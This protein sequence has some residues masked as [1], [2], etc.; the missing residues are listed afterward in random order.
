M[1][2]I[3]RSRAPDTQSFQG[4]VLKNF[5]HLSEELENDTN[6]MNIAI[7]AVIIIEFD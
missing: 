4:K 3:G 5:S 7:L 6:L 1:R 2:T